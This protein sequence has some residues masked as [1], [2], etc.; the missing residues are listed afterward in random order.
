MNIPITVPNNPAYLTT[1]D[2]IKRST[3]S[4]HSRYGS[5]C[6]STA[7]PLPCDVDPKLWQRVRLRA[8]RRFPLANLSPS[9]SKLSSE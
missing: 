9:D 7:S 8:Q 2:P 1:L 6:C 3:P 4:L 5:F